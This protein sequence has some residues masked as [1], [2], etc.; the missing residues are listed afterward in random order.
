GEEHDDGRCLPR[1]AVDHWV[2]ARKG[3]P[4]Q[5][6]R[7]AAGPPQEG[8]RR[9]WAEKQVRVLPHTERD[10]IESG[11]EERERPDRQE[12]RDPA[13]RDDERESGTAAVRTD[14]EPTERR[15]RQDG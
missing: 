15:H 6:S 4:G 1:D 3:E 10:E 7:V 14:A 13:I 9:K 8:R 5:G 12:G 11:R 2:D